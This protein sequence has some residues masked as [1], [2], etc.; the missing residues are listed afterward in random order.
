MSQESSMIVHQATLEQLEEIAPLF[1][2][3][4][5]FYGQPS[6]LE[7]ARQF[8]FNR[9]EHQQSVI[10]IAIE[11][12]SGKA[13][14]FT[15][16]YPVFSSIS[17]RRAWILNDLYVLEQERGRGAAKL[18]LEQAKRHGQLTGAKG[19]ELSTAPDNLIAQALYEKNGYE[20][21]ETFL[22]YFLTL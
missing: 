18:L 7:G 6:D 11:Q 8:L 9:F 21:D 20:R 3:Y 10:F 13:I 14:G 1:D 4:R 22:H 12:A 2:A 5:I 15:Q 17:M 16:L 19:I